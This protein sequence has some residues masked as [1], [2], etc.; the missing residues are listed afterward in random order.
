MKLKIKKLFSGINLPK[1]A[2]SG[3]AGLD[4]F[5]RE[6]FL[7]KSGQR[8]TF[9][10]GFRAGLSKGYVALIWDKGGLPHKAGIHTLAGV[11]DSNYRG[12]WLVI[13]INLG[14]KS[15][16]IKKGDK[17]A[18]ILIQKVEKVKIIEVLKLS[19]TKRADGKFGSSGR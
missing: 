11:I 10:L 13:L 15:Y 5:S 14:K 12:E 16:Q 19:K 7:L 1:Y 17:I 9:Y 4:V 18:Q 2:Y 8:H 3:D 6:N